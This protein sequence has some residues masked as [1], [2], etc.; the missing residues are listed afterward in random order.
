MSIFPAGIVSESGQTH[1]KIS[2]P[3]SADR[4][5]GNIVSPTDRVM[6]TKPAVTPGERFEAAGMSEK[7]VTSD[8]ETAQRIA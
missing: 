6:T 3:A 1:A 2:A 5:S 4:T 7:A 8:P